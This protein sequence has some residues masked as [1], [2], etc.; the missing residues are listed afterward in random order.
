MENKKL[1]QR[2]LDIVAKASAVAFVLF[3]ETFSK[4]LVSVIKAEVY[5]ED[6]APK[7]EITTKE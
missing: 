6:E 5:K 2:V 1:Y 3:L 4:D 7:K